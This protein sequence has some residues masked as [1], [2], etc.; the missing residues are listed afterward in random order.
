MT[1]IPDRLPRILG[2]WTA[3]AVVVGTVIG[4]GVFKKAD[5][6]RPGRGEPR[7]RPRRLGPRRRPRRCWGRWPTPRWRPC[8]RARPAATTSSCARAT[9]GWPASCGA[10]SSSG[11]SAPPRSP[12]WPPSSPSRSTTCSVRPTPD[13]PDVDVL[14]SGGRPALTALVIAWLWPSTSA[15]CGWGGGLQVFI[16]AR[17]GRLAA[18]PSSRCRS[19]SLA[20]TPVRGAPPRPANLSPAWPASWGGGAL[21][22]FGAA[23]LGVLW[24]YHGWMNVAPIAEEVRDPQRNLPLAAA[25]R[26]RHRSSPSTWGATSPII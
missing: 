5:H 23:F 6:R 19:S 14:A 11:S 22:G 10:G 12:P 13:G 20:S 21:G 17:Q 7:P 24:A 18:A 16:T 8:C 4:S 2:P 1:P 15:A 9:A 26:R 3:A 25:R